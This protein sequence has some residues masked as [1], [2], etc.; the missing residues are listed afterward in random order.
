MQSYLPINIFPLKGQEHVFYSHTNIRQ[1]RRVPIR[2][3]GK[4]GAKNIMP[5]LRIA[6]VLDIT[7]ADFLK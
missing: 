2:R 7:R 3:R 5:K 1:P 4:L 6:R